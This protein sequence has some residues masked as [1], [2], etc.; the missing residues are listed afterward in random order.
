VAELRKYDVGG[1][2]RNKLYLQAMFT[3]PHDMTLSAQLRGESND[4]KAEL[5]RTGWDTYGTSLQWDWQ[6]SSST[7]ASAWYGFDRADLDTAN[8]NDLAMTPDPELGGTSYPEANRWWLSDRQRNHY[9]G[10]N[11]S[12]RIHK[13]TLTGDWNYISSKGDTD[14]RYNSAGAL[15]F[16]GDATPNLAG[17]FPTMR[18]RINTVTLGVN[19]PVSERLNLRLFDTW[20]KGDLSDWHYSGFDSGQ[21]IGTMVYTDG[22]PEDYSVNMVGLMM[23]MKL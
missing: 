10:A 14:Y 3:L 8:V 23:E 6:P 9:A 21:V 17:A 11:L 15:A 13:A 2:T 22:G 5:G 16:P 20:Q 18:W 1:L 4:Y 7:V 19:F 12:Q